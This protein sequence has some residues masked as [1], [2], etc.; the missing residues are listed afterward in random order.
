MQQQGAPTPIAPAE[1]QLGKVSP[2]MVCVVPTA[3]GG[4]A[5]SALQILVGY[6]QRT[7]LPN[8]LLKGRRVRCDGKSET[9]QFCAMK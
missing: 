5:N 9:R 3:A 4:R 2:S 8:G 6:Q 7:D 1:G